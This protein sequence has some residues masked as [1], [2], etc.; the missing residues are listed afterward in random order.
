MKATRLTIA[1]LV[2]AI[3]SACSSVD[4]LIVP[5]GE[6]KSV[7]DNR[8]RAIQQLNQA[9]NCCQ[10][11]A[12]FA[13]TP[14]PADFEKLLVIDGSTPVFTFEDG[15]SHF[16][17]FQ[18]PQNSGDLLITLSAQ[19]DKTLFQPKAI[20][21]DSQF[22][23]TRTLGENIF[24]YEPAKLLDGNRLEGEFTIDRTYIGNPNNETYLVI[25]TPE[26]KLNETTTIMNEGKLMA[27]SLAVVDP[28]LKDPE[29]PHS[30]W[31]L[32]KMT[33]EDLSKNVGQV[34]VFKPVYQETVAANAPRVEAAPNKLVIAPAAATTAV[35]ASTAQTVAQPVAA[36]TPAPATA[37]VASGSM[38]AET[39]QMYNQLIQK[40]VSG[41]DIEKAMALAGEAERAGSRT[42]KPTLIDA[43]KHSQK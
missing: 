31:G 3:T 12:T 16:V 22:R 36:A 29:I 9:Q 21:L 40:A 2:A 37:A 30:P 15:K 28:G 24:K 1:L 34:N 27:K 33:V 6:Y 42:A 10:S 20:L 41:G 13:F 19:I 23:V 35:A 39:E 17:A 5:T 32:V 8:E 26:N 11:V 4:N 7:L 38:M 14:I 18:L 25:Y 43:I